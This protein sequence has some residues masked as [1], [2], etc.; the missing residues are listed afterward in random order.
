MGRQRSSFV[1]PILRLE[2][3]P[4]RLEFASAREIA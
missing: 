1:L 3:L 2:F 4:Y